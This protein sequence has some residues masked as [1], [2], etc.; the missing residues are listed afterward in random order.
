M[1]FLKRVLSQRVRH[2]SFDTP[3]RSEFEP[4]LEAAMRRVRCIQDIG[5][6]IGFAFLPPY[7]DAPPIH[8][9]LGRYQNISSVGSG[10]D[11][12]SRG[13][14]LAKATSETIE[15]ALWR[16]Q[17]NYCNDGAIQ[18]SISSLGSSCL[19]LEELAGFSPETRAAHP[20]L[21]FDSKTEFQWSR[22]LY[23]DTLAP[24]LIPSQLVSARYVG[25]M[26]GREP[27]LRESNSNGLAVAENFEKASHRGL[28]ELVERDAFMITYFNM[29]TPNR[30][31][32]KTITNDSIQR[33]LALCAQYD[34]MCD[35]LLLPTDAPVHVICVTIRDSRGGPALTVAAK[36]HHYTEVAIRGA[37][38][39]ALSSWILARFSGGYLRPTIPHP[40][41]LLERIAYWAK[42]EHA[43]QLSW[44]WSGKLI[45][46]PT[47]T[48]ATSLKILA[49]ALRKNNCVAAAI[50]LSTPLLKR[51]GIYAVCVTS[52]NLQPVN[53]QSDTI[54]DYGVRLES[55]PK[56]FGHTPKRNVQLANHPFP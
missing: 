33:L 17:I 54:Y 43:Q 45:P 25:D 14:A 55:I 6:D 11:P 29:I 5:F 37:V 21:V 28:L 8:I 48:H 40:I 36:A 4:D 49:Q 24:A 15:R 47:S 13:T 38:I 22:G 23:L 44:L 12:E 26:K 42:P 10:F 41:S 52:P 3:P 50:E 20:A 30:I 18:G 31:D 27:L 53:L 56:K 19:P 51:L 46:M 35:I 1:N 16:E 2:T 39:E 34:L 9:C 7:P 32:P